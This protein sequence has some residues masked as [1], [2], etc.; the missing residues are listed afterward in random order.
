[1]KIA[2]FCSA[3]DNISP[4][5]FEMTRSF[6]EFLAKRGDTLVYGG[7]NSGLM[8]CVAK[9]AF[10]AG[11]HTIGVLP[12]MVEENVQASEYLSER[13][14]VSNLSER[15][16]VMMDLSNVFVALPGGVGTLDEIFSVVASNTIGY[17]H[18][19]TILYNMCGFWDKTLE[20]LMGMKEAGML[21][22]EMSDYI[23]CVDSLEEMA[24]YLK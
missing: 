2:V 7:C 1:M 16:Q 18:K 8:E 4:E 15:K 3:N 6:G 20:M 17:H 11:A 19:R 21:R 14:D 22:G 10:Q 24:T 9:A 5:Y 12:T 23:V 13:I